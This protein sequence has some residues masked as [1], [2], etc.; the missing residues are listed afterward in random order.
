LKFIVKDIKKCKINYIIERDGQTTH[1]ATGVQEV[2]VFCCCGVL[3]TLGL[4]WGRTQGKLL[5][6]TLLK[7]DVWRTAMSSS[8][9]CSIPQLLQQSSSSSTAAAAAAAKSQKA[10]GLH[11]GNSIIIPALRDKYAAKVCTRSL[12]WLLGLCLFVC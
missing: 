11:S 9:S 12:D 3:L 8:S 1:D 5:D 7:A 6:V 10:P 4:G 2:F